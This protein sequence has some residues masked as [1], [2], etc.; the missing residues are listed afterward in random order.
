MLY[1]VIAVNTETSGKEQESK[2]TKVRKEVHGA[3]YMLPH[4]MKLHDVL[5]GAYANYKVCMHCL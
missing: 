1:I 3:F 5:K 2:D 4:Y